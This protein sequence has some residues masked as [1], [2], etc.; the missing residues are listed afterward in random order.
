MLFEVDLYLR[1]RG[2]YWRVRCTASHGGGAFGIFGVDF[3]RAAEVTA[4][5]TLE[6]DREAAMGCGVSSSLQGY[7]VPRGATIT[8]RVQPG[9]AKQI[10]LTKRNTTQQRAA[11]GKRSC[12]F[13]PI[14]PLSQTA[15]ERTPM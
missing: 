7:T 1:A 9:R 14:V 11:S 3:W 10:G 4:N 8:Q 6:S 12:G 13:V 15:R 2:R 5:A